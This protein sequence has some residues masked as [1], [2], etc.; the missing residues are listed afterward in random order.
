M[1]DNNSSNKKVVVVGVDI[2]SESIKV[3]LGSKTFDCEIVRNEVGGH[4]TPNLISF[5]ATSRQIGQTA[6]AKSKNAVFQINRLVTEEIS[7]DDDTDDYF[8][9]QAFYPFE[10][11]HTTGMVHNLDYNG[12]MRS[13]SS[14]ALLAMLFGNIH[15]N[16]QAAVHRITN[17]NATTTT[18]DEW[19]YHYVVS[20]GHNTTPKAQDEWLDAAYAAGI[21]KVKLVERSVCHKYCYQRKFP[22]HFSNNDNNNDNA[23]VVVDMGH[24]QTTVAVIGTTAATTQKKED[25]MDDNDNTNEP[26]PVAVVLSCVRHKSLGAGLVDIR[27]WD[28]FQIP[29]VPKNARGGQRLLDGTKN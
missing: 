19:E 26:P 24:T 23:V 20:I 28:H 2:G 13:F 21:S 5:S 12:S 29:G 6:N 17:T 25:N 18:T 11:D 22:D 7:Q 16:V 10:F 4:T 9:F 8:P 14:S 1:S 15:T 27:L 3:V